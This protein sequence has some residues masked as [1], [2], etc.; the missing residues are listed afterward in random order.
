M[1]VF[2]G[3]SVIILSLGSSAFAEELTPVVSD[4]YTQVVMEDSY[5]DANTAEDVD[6]QVESGMSSSFG[7]DLDAYYSSASW[8]LGFGQQE[9]PEIANLAEIGIYQS[10]IADSLTPDFIIL[11]AS[12]NPLPMLGVYLREK[13]PGLY[14][15]G[16]GNAGSNLVESI[17]SGFA[18]PFAISLFAG[19]VVRFAAPEGM[20]SQGDNMGYVGYLLSAGSQHIQH[21]VLIPDDWVEIEWKIKG[22]RETDAQSLSWSVR[23]GA[24]LHSNE[25]I[26]DT[27]MVGIRRDRIDFTKSEDALMRDFGFEYRLD[28]LQ[29][30]LHPSRQ[31][32][33]VDKHWPLDH[34][35]LAVSLGLGAIWQ[36]EDR[37]LGA[38]AERQQRWSFV[39]RPNISF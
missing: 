26:S 1:N 22:R 11:E 3:L 35:K 8:V 9:I 36:G 16:A 33:M 25:E 12:V 28:L 6:E 5:S 14:A 24:K 23:S 19:R 4:V 20:G 2:L 34:G 29:A 7:Y 18:D 21:N 27:V 10:L 13:Q 38:L 37:Y 15:K 31:L 32:F 17:T 30:N 39:F